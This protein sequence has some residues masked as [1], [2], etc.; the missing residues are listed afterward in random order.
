[1]DRR[2]GVPE[3]SRPARVNGGALE[4]VGRSTTRIHN[5]G[6][7]IHAKIVWERG[8]RAAHAVQKSAAVH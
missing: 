6:L 5:F 4:A 3:G 7:P 1:M 8:E 2:Q